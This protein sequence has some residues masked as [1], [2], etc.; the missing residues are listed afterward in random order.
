[1]LSILSAARGGRPIRR[2]YH[3]KSIT[4]T[5]YCLDS[6]SGTSTWNK[7]GPNAQIVSGAC[8]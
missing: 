8:P 3:L 7:T 1:V 6:S 2:G 4:A 5:S